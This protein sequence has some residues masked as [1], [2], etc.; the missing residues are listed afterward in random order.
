[1]SRGIL[2]HSPL[3]TLDD[4]P[5]SLYGCGMKFGDIMQGTIS[6][7]DQKGRG[8][9]SYPLP[10]TP[11]ETRTVVVPFTAPGDEVETTFVKRDQGKWVTHLNKVISPSPERITAPCPHAGVCGGCLWQH[12]AYPAQCALKEKMIAR[13]LGE[14]GHIERPT[15]VMACPSPLHYRNRMDYVFGWQGQLGLK[16]YGSWNHYL[17]LQTCLLLDEETPHIL[18]QARSWMREFRLEPWD[19]KRHTGQL[20]YCVIRLGKNTG[21]RMIMLV[22]KDLSTLSPA[23]KQG[24]KERFAHLSTTLYLGENPTITDLSSATTLELLHGNTLFTEEVNGLPYLIHPNSFFQTNTQMAARLQNTVLDFLGGVHGKNI[25]DLY[26]GLGF[27]GIACAKRGATVYGRE[28]DAPAIELAKENSRRNGVE[29]LTT[30]ESGTVESFAW[31]ERRPD[32]VIID[33]PRAGLHPHALETLLEKAPPTIIYVSCN[34]HSFAK[35]LVSFKKKYRVERM[36]ALDLFPQ[37][38]HVELVTKLVLS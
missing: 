8:T 18:E 6:D 12:L 17:D 19:A 4:Q 3:W 32:A 16:E 33:P 10:A 7:V 34:Y 20:R 24:L 13:A 23:A 21:E 14:L 22:I 30:F 27:F 11:N 25:L 29:S 2:T 38:P 37:T 28:L 9:F 36:T 35:E 15:E 5:F 26:C 1:M 31:G